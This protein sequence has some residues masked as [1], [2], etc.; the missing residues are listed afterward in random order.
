MASLVFQNFPSLSGH[1]NLGADVI[2]VGRHPANQIVIDEIYISGFHAELH[3]LPDGS[4]EV[5][6]LDSFNGTYVNGRKVTR[7]PLREGDTIVFALYQATYSDRPG[8]S[9]AAAHA[10]HAWTTAAQQKRKEVMTEPTPV[11]KPAWMEEVPP[12]EPIPA[13]FGPETLRFGGE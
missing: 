10:G 2:R 7:F 9:E 3:R 11:Q 12:A 6:D 5:V 8:S 4:F 1:L 13:R